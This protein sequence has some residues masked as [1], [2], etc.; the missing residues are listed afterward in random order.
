LPELPTAR[1]PRVFASLLPLCFPVLALAFF[2]PLVVLVLLRSSG[3][4]GFDRVTEWPV[5]D[6]KEPSGIVYHP[7]RDTLFVCG[8]Q[9][10]IGEISLDGRLLAS[11]HIGGDLEA[12]TVA[13]ATGLLYVVREGH[14]ILLELRPDDFKLTRRFNI[15]R[16]FRGDA[17]YLKRG[18]NGIEGLTFVPDAKHAE[19][20]RFFAVNEDD[21]PVLIELAVPLRSMSGKFGEARVTASHGLSV[22]PL[23]GLLWLTD[24]RK[25]LISSALWKA[26]YVFDEAGRREASVPVPGLMQ[27]GIA[28]LPD[29]SFVIVQDVGGLI[30]WSPES[31]PFIT[32][33]PPEA[34]AG[35]E[36]SVESEK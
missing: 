24:A 32:A 5:A 1:R 27:E 19:D 10:D 21:P 9:G 12:I 31:D 28:R 2:A 25:F 4:A 8:D 33:S 3:L 20:G 6:F 18:G 14:E 29:G 11:A 16:G 30:K 35:D 7:G 26:V 22:R 17:E 36:P 13:P 15:Q 34:K 23:S